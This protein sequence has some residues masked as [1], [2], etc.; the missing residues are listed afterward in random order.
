MISVMRLLARPSPYGLE[1]SD[2]FLY[3]VSLSRRFCTSATILSLSVPTSF[4]VPYS[5]A[6]GRSVVLLKTR[7]G[8]PRDELLPA[9]RRNLS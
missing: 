7:T 4:T 8:L 9:L 3:S 5:T 1:A 6:S 2:I